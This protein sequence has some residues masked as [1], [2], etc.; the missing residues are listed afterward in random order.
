MQK[1]FIFWG[2]AGFIYIAYQTPKRQQLGG[3]VVDKKYFKQELFPRILWFN[4]SLTFSFWGRKGVTSKNMT[5][6]F[7]EEKA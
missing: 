6:Q 1:P 2:V 5:L 7:L 4:S 3:G